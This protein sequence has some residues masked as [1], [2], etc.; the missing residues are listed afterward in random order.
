[1][2]RT[3]YILALLSATATAHA[4]VCMAKD[5]G[6]RFFSKASIENIE[7]VSTA[8]KPMINTA[9][10]EV[11]VKIPVRSFVFEKPLMQEH[12]NENYMESDK[13]PYAIF[14]GKI[15]EPVDYKKDG[16]YNVTVTGT[17]DMHGVVK[18]RTVDASLVV[19]GDN[20]NVSSKFM[21]HIADHNIKIPSAV[22]ESVAEDVEVTVNAVL[23]PFK[24]K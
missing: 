18:E 4:Q 20:I 13:Y 15:N 21:I 11:V 19:K 12:F 2:K 8:A 22:I 5:C 3:M 24:K 10:N 16:T 14:K 23:E 9:N 6:I 1:M 7:G 17:L